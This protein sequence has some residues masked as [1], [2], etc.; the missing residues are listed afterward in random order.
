MNP[1]I[2]TDNDLIQPDDW[3][4]YLYYIDGNSI[5]Q[6]L[7]WQ[8][9]SDNFGQ[10]WYGT[11]IEDFIKQRLIN[12]KHNIPIRFIEFARGNIKKEPNINMPN[13]TFIKLLKQGMSLIDIENS[14]KQNEK[15]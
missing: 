12:S 13:E 15:N 4:R 11:K 1:I 7:Q 6:T 3:Y 5:D 10:V 14:N 9:V 8:K 2:L